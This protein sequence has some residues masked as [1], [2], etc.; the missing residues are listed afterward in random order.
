MP[1][2]PSIHGPIKSTNFMSA[3][4]GVIPVEELSPQDSGEPKDVEHG[5]ASSSSNCL[6]GIDLILV[7]SSLG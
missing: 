3:S 4:N 2:C 5:T 6:H 7:F 1:F